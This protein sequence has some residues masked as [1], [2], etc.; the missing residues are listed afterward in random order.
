MEN[1][2]RFF[3]MR[4]ILLLNKIQNNLSILLNLFVAFL[5]PK[6]LN[7]RVD[8]QRRRS[9]VVEPQITNLIMRVR[10]PSPAFFVALWA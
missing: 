6:C 5:F 9:S 7:I 4:I 8:F 3:N 1:F 10:F 2:V